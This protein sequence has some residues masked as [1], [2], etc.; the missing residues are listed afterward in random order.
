M[1]ARG[2]NPKSVEHI[3]DVRSRTGKPFVVLWY[4]GDAVRPHVRALRQAGVLVADSPSALGRVV[5]ALLGPERD[6][7]D[8]AHPPALTAPEGTVGGG[9]RALALLGEA[10]LDIAPMRVAADADAATAA[11]DEIGYPVVVKSADEDIAHRTEL[12]LV[13]VR[14]RSGA[15]VR[16]AVLRMLPGVGGAPGRAGHTWLVQ[17]MVAGGVEL[18]VSVRDAG[19]LGVFGGVGVGGAAVELLRDVE[20]VPLPCDR[21]TLVR[22]LRRL[23]LA[24]LVFGFRGAKPIDVDWLLATLN[25]LGAIVCERN[26]AEIELNPVIVGEKG[27]HIVDALHVERPGR[28]TE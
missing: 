4:G 8:D 17:R 15:D 5:K 11:A 27:G 2:W 23:R 16:D 9:A 26:L 13:A 20:Q 21:E 19:R 14:L 10:G 7:A 28:A 1:G 3:L 25:R 12:G 24:E 22:A 18:V 6:L